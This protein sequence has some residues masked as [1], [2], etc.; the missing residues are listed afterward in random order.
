[1]KKLFLLCI[2]ILVSMAMLI[3]SCDREN[4]NNDDNGNTENPSD[5]PGDNPG[6][7]G[8]DYPST[9]VVIPNAVTD[10]DGNSYDA[11]QI[12]NQVWMAKN[13]RTTHYADGTSIPGG[14]T[15]M[16]V[17]RLAPNNDESIVPQ[18][19]YLYSWSAAMH[20]A[21]NSNSNPSG[22]QGV[23]PNGWH[24]PSEAEWQQLEDYVKSQ[25]IYSGGTAKALAATTGW[26]V[27][28][29]PN[30]PG[31]EP[32]TNNAS[33]FSALPA[34]TNSMGGV[35]M[36]FGD[37]STMWSTTELP[38]SSSTHAFGYTVAYA[39]ENASRSTNNK[40]LTMSVRC[41]RN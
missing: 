12:G 35:C 33:G 8:S 23:C 24:L 26:T 5:D 30:T 25:P 21:G 10:Y 36:L 27:S 17:S 18:Y 1:M 9:A 7:G 2:T 11:V 13:L 4:V 38:E 31:Y 37:Q 32:S 22:V 39:F 3:I 28:Y 19:G 41:V 20:G 29:A 40:S 14:S 34:G 6:T 16:V 15:G